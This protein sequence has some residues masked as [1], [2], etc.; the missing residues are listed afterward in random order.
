MDTLR[1][2]FWD[3]PMDFVNC[4]VSWR[5]TY[6]KACKL[7]GISQRIRR[8]VKS[9]L[10]MELFLLSLTY[11]HASSKIQIIYLHLIDLYVACLLYFSWFSSSTYVQNAGKLLGFSAYVEITEI[12][13]LYIIRS[14]N[15]CKL[16]GFWDLHVDT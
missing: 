15:P 3:G 11:V 16:L 9:S 6:G 8:Y 10:K 1:I 14:R 7:P 2:N 4:D 13:I 5:V 12:I